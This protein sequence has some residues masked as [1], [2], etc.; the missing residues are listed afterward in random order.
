MSFTIKDSD[1]G[2][3]KNILPKPHTLCQFQMIPKLD[4]DNL[5]HLFRGSSTLQ[6]YDFNANCEQ[7]LFPAGC[8]DI[9][10]CTYPE[11]G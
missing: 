1:S 11:S 8:T 9:T 3:V 7:C 10:Y 6:L 4:T 5:D 2:C